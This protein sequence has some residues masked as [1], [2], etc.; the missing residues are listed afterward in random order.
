M[1]LSRLKMSDRIPKLDGTLKSDG[2][3]KVQWSVPKLD[4]VTSQSSMADLG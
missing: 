3:T 4:G 2:L 1:L